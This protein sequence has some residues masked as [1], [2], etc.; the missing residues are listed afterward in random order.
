M[1]IVTDYDKQLEDIINGSSVLGQINGT[2]E[3]FFEIDLNSREILV[4]LSFQ[5]AIVAGDHKAETIWFKCARY[6]D[7]I[8]L[9]ADDTIIDIAFCTPDDKIGK[10]I[11]ENA[12][13]FDSNTIVFSWTIT[14]KV[15]P[16]GG[17]LKFAVHIYKL[18]GN[19]YVY[20]LNTTTAELEIANGL[21]YSFE[22]LSENNKYLYDELNN[23]ID[24][25]DSA[26][27]D[28]IDTAV[29][30]INSTIEECVDNVNS[31]LDG[32]VNVYSGEGVPVKDDKYVQGDIYIDESGT[33]TKGIRS[34]YMF[35]DNWKLIYPVVSNVDIKLITDSTV[36]IQ[37]ENNSDV[38]CGTVESLTITFPDEI[39]DNFEAMLSFSIG[40]I[41]ATVA[42]PEGLRLSGADVEDGVFIPVKER[43][44]TIG[45]WYDGK[46][47]NGAVR[48]YDENV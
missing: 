7:A 19:K 4:P 21:G 39:E 14:D 30:D 5:R 9:L 20:K 24:E 11:A 1:A 18:D 47:I 36:D 31:A 45:F 41:L 17:T 12:K 40:D 37:I 23:K 16:V 27:I 2:D 48:G 25:V 10:D 15:V 44:Y 43:R 3:A 6:F 33:D 13:V 28:K 42:Y 26:L 35:T 8:D 32:K 29:N 38:R 22:D 34:V 46:Y